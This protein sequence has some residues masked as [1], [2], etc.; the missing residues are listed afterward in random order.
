MNQGP[1]RT[2][3]Q[4]VTDSLRE[5][6]LCGDLAPGE[7]LQEVALAESLNVSRTPVREALRILA[8]DGLLSYAPNRGYRVRAFSIR[9]VL[10][11]FRVRASMEGLGCRLIAERGLTEQEADEIAAILA[12]GDAL[13]AEGQVSAADHDAWSRMNYDFHVCLLRLAD[14][15]LLRKVARDAQ[16]IPIVN[17]GTFHW[18]REEDFRRSH[19]QHHRIF[20]MLRAGSPDRAEFWMREHILYGAEIARRGL[21]PRA[22]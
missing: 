10:I 12:R 7:K 1:A 14:S 13:L 3:S 9:D 4:T 6:I 8:D 22:V 17:A 20:Q 18:Y 19:D 21:P 11:A 2:R 15:H 16:T 5:R